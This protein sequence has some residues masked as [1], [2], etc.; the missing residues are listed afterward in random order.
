MN[1]QEK[2]SA[3][4]QWWVIF[5]MGK[6]RL[7]SS[8]NLFL[9]LGLIIVLS[10]SLYWGWHGWRIVVPENLGNSP[11]NIARITQAPQQDPLSFVVIGDTR[12]GSGVFEKLL[13]GIEDED[14]LFMV[15]LGD[16]VR[17]PDLGFH[18][19]FIYEINEV[20]P[21]F[22]VLLVAGNH[23]LDAPGGPET[24]KRLYGPLNFSFRYNNDLFIFLCDAYEGWSRDYLPFLEE[25]LRNYASESKRVFVFTHIPPTSLVS[26]YKHRQM[27]GEEE[28]MKLVKEYGIDY[29][30]AADFHGYLR[31]SQEPT[32]FFISGGGGS[33]LKPKKFGRFFHLIKLTFSHDIVEEQILEVDQIIDDIEDRA[34]YASIAYIFPFLKKYPYLG[35]LIYLLLFLSLFLQFRWLRR[36]RPESPIRASRIGGPPPDRKARLGRAAPP[37]L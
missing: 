2:K 26:E 1:S 20:G 14:I 21:K 9:L 7:R 30:F 36:K 23:D 25:N 37:N 11:E 18:K 27:E 4:S 13:V 33:E 16:F 19:Y 32:E 3:C 15:I 24:F 10:A 22:P 12:G 28:F 29:V 6:G 5:F 31:A 35:V 17:T 34:E 8:I